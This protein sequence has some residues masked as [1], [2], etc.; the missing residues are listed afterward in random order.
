MVKV[1]ILGY[2]VVGSGVAEI[3]TGSGGDVRKK[4]DELIG[5]KYILDLRSF[6]DSPLA[7]Q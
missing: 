7:E 3:L 5:L 4:A 1:A 2:G 6:P